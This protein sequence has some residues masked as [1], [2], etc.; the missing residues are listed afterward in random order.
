M[1]RLVCDIC[2]FLTCVLRRRGPAPLRLMVSEGNTVISSCRSPSSSLSIPEKRPSEKHPHSVSGPGLP[3]TLPEQPRCPGWTLREDRPRLTSRLSQENTVKELAG[4]RDGSVTSKSGLQRSQF[5]PVPL[6]GVRRESESD[7]SENRL[8][9]LSQR[10]P[11]H[12]SPPLSV[13]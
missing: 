3:G 9:A 7:P 13:F 2:I 5:P 12:P 10:P 1:S 11:S 8:P 6:R 4:G